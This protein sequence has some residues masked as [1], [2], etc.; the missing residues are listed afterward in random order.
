VA[1]RHRPSGSH[2][3]VGSVSRGVWSE[4]SNSMSPRRSRLD[5]AQLTSQS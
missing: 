5:A 4:W 2:W 1:A 3:P